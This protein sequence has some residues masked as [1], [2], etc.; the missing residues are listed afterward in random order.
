MDFNW[1][2]IKPLADI[3]WNT[4]RLIVILING[5]WNNPY[6]TD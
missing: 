4:G 2:V 5:L 3:P 6:I 1:A